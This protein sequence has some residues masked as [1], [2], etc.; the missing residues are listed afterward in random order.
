MTTRF[1][2]PYYIKD[3]TKPAR[4][5]QPEQGRTW[6]G[7]YTN[8]SVLHDLDDDNAPIDSKLWRSYALGAWMKLERLTGEQYQI[9][10]DGIL[11]PNVIG[12]FSWRMIEE[13][14]TAACEQ[15][16]R[17]PADGVAIIGAAH[18]W[19]TAKQNEL[20]KETK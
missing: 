3:P 1:N 15:A 20:E 17:T 6:G 8:K 10:A 13:M 2:D 7:K 4:I 19:L 18:A 14:V 12:E 9:I 11:P 16:E 5:I